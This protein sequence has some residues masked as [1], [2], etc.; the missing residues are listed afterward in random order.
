MLHSDEVA[1][2]DIILMQNAAFMDQIYEDYTE[3][4]LPVIPIVSKTEFRNAAQ[5]PS[6]VA[7]TRALVVVLTAITLHMT[8]GSAEGSQLHQLRITALVV[9]ALQIHE[10]MLPG[11]EV[12]VGWVLLSLLTAVCFMAN[13]QQPELAFY[14]LQEAQ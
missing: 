5:E 1:N 10:P 3:Y 7:T 2:Q 11:H 12:D 6:P 9:N 4:V 14:Y 13:H 8:P